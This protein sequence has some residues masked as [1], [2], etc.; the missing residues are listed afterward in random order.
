MFP[1]VSFCSALEALP[2]IWKS[3][4]YQSIPNQ[5]GVSQSYCRQH[6]PGTFKGVVKEQLLH[7]AMTNHHIM[8]D[9]FTFE[10][11]IKYGMY[12]MQ[13]T[14]IA[15]GK[16][17]SGKNWQDLIHYYV[18]KLTKNGVTRGVWSSQTCKGLYIGKVIESFL[19]FGSQ[20]LS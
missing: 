16:T 15:H 2:A 4:Y 19:K 5:Q 6:E 20:D 18:Y 17:E 7:G 3:T 11:Q 8:L 12:F 14:V 10:E 13:G 1:I 9:H